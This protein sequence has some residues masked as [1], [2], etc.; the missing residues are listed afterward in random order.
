MTKQQYRSVFHYY[1]LTVSAFLLYVGVDDVRNRDRWSMGDWVT[2]Y[3]GG[4]VR[5]GLI[6]QAALDL[7]RHTPHLSLYTWT[8]LIQLICYATLFLTVS[9]LLRGLTWNLWMVALIYS[10]ATLSFTIFDPAFAFRKEILFLALL[11]VL[12]LCLMSKRFSVSSMS[13]FTA[14]GMAVLILSHEAMILYYPYILGAFLIALRDVRKAL[15]ASLPGALVSICTFVIAAKH[16]GNIATANAICLSLG[17]RSLLS[18]PCSGS[19]RYLATTTASAHI[20]VLKAIAYWHLSYVMPFLLVMA[21]APVVLGITSL[22]HQEE[23]RFAWWSLIA[24]SILA[25]VISVPLFIYAFDWNRWVY[26]HVLASLLLMLMIERNHQQ[27]RPTFQQSFIPSHPTKRFLCMLFLT[28]SIF[29]W[30]LSFYHHFPLPAE[31]LLVYVN[32]R[33]RGLPQHKDVPAPSN[34]PSSS[35]HK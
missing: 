15:I 17:E 26:V 30:Q 20:D 34:L 25:W 18:G 9:K 14:L 6:G 2:N 31:E 13:L 10:P 32:R 22:W 12:G 21:L 33:I 28:T 7:S 5:R 19:I 35:G 1:L 8:F 29:G 23:Q 3:A 27:R 4:F 24:C 16:Q 11:G